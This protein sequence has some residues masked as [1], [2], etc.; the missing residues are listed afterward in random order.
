MNLPLLAQKL[1]SLMLLAGIAALALAF[2]EGLAQLLGFSL[3]GR[4]Y[5]AS[6]TLEIGAVLALFSMALETWRRGLPD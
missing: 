4:L 1:A 5:A 6:R 2:G 3:V